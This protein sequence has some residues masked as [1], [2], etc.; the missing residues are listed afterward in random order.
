MR[1]LNTADAA[2]TA[3]HVAP[4]N[5]YVFLWK[6]LTQSVGRYVGGTYIHLGSD[7]SYS[8]GNKR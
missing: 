2:L 8:G 3:L 6:W 7:R 4:R 5:G 1:A